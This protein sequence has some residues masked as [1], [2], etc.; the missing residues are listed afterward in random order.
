MTDTSVADNVSPP[1]APATPGTAAEALNS[2]PPAPAF[3]ES[4]EDAGAKEW[5]QKAGFKSA[6]DVAKLA[7]K[8]DAFKDVD[9][10]TLKALPKADDPNAVVAHLQA[11]G[12]PTDVAAYG[13]DKIEGVDPKF[14]GAIGD[15]MTKA[16]ILPFQAQMLADAQI[17]FTKAQA[18]ADVREEKIAGERELAQLDTEWGSEATA[19]KELGR[20]AL[21]A[22]ARAAGVD[23]TEFLNYVESGAGAGGAL[24]IA[25]YFGQFIKESDFIDGDTNTPAAVPLQERMYKDI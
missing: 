5:V 17:A 10:A 12:A 25:A 6:E 9:P 18:E 3:Y 14:A 19:K 8:F 24:K 1:A 15:A 13:F 2:P 22:A 4:F 21:K 11:L 7:Q 23:P 20:R 16:G